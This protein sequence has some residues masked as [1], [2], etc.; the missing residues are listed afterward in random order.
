MNARG[1]GRNDPCPCGSGKKFKRCC[2]NPAAS[3]DFGTNL[4]PEVMAAR[5]ELAD[6]FDA[7]RAD[8][9]E[10]EF[11]SLEEVQAFLDRRVARHN[12]AA[13]ADFDGLS[14][15]Q[16]R[17]LL[18]R[19][20]DTPDVIRFAEVLDAEP[21]GA[22]A[23]CFR[24]LDEELDAKGIKL[25]AKD[26]LPRDLVRRAAARVHG[27]DAEIGLTEV[28][29]LRGED[30]Y[31]E[32]FFVHRAAL[33]A[34]LL[35]KKH[36]RLFRT[37]R[38]EELL[39]A[40][41]HAAVFR[42]LVE[43]LATQFDWAY[44]DGYAPMAIVQGSVAYSLRA[45]KRH[46]GTWRPTSFYEESFLRAFPAVMDEC[47]ADRHVPAL[48]YVAQ[49]YRLRFLKRFAVPCGLIEADPPLEELR[50]DEEARIRS[51]PQL[52]GFVQLP[53]DRPSRA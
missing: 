41:G 23:E 14:P 44:F 12:R 49:A 13:N 25:T 6:V 51:T 47:P 29:K 40:G 34:G 31:R 4:P 10:R 38:C 2:G 39:D 36:G 15:D 20:F 17:R 24:C 28:G 19:P 9:S 50:Y 46:G 5:E 16:V 42:P 45:L 22:F 32:I 33:M 48:D 8:L 30:D 11:D 35:R 1:P 26:N 3:V 7:L 18:D 43:A 37:R 53:E 52:E 27:E 21:I